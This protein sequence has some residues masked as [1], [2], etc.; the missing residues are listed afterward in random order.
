MSRPISPT[1][2]NAAKQ[3]GARDVTRVAS[4]IEKA[5]ELGHMTPRAAL[6]SLHKWQP[7]LFWSKRARE[8]FGGAT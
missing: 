7:E 4:G 2:M 5:C 1:L 6:A 8:Y 3:A